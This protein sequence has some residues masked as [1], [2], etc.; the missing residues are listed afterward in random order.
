VIL[1]RL[2]LLAGVDGQ[3]GSWGSYGSCSTTCGDGTKT[4]TRIC[5]NPV[6][7]YGGAVCAGSYYETAA[8]KLQECRE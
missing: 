3:W 1:S 6:P 8:C 5:D 2:L 4:R 7:A